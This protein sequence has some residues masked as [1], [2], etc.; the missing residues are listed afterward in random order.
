MKDELN[1]LK[2]SIKK[3][4]AEFERLAEFQN[5]API[6]NSIESI[7]RIERNIEDKVFLSE[8]IDFLN[9][10]LL[11]AKALDYFPAFQSYAESLHEIMGNL[12][13]YLGQP[14]TPPVFPSPQKIAYDFYKRFNFSD[15]KI[16]SHLQGIDFRFKVSTPQL[17]AHRILAQWKLMS[18]PSGDYY[19]YLGKN[20]DCLGINSKQED[21]KGKIGTRTEH[22]YKINQ[23]LE[24]LM[25][26]AAPVLDIWSVQSQPVQ[27][28]GGCIQFFNADKNHISEV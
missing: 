11:A 20:P 9:L 28:R 5:F 3:S 14:F 26:T 13:L 15:K 17:G 16:H 21:L 12:F 27:T 18:L 8:N 2:D 19:C 23:K 24:F 4:R 10:G 22:R 25:S 6:Y 1:E 7:S